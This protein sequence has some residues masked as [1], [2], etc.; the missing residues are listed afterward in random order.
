VTT[1]DMCV[2]MR[3]WVVEY[4]LVIKLCALTLT[5]VERVFFYPAG[6]I[7][8]VI[9]PQPPTCRTIMTAL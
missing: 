3:V 8:M 6:G 9:N 4:G 7:G 5:L 1:Y 2:S